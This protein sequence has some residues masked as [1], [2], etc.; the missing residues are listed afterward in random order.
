M[1]EFGRELKRLFGAESLAPRDGMTGGDAALMELLPLA[2]LRA[3]AKARD[4][5]AGRVGEK[6]RASRELEAAQVWRELA[7]RTGDAAALR[8]AAATAE[9]A[10]RRFEE[11]RRVEGAARARIEQ[12]RC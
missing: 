1:F 6:D 8:K 11:A 2:M 10:A 4:V 7:R 9:S 5:A 3:E 12:A